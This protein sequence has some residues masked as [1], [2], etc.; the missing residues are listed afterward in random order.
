MWMAKFGSAIVLPE[1]FEAEDEINVVKGI[2]Q[3]REAYNHSP[4]DAEDLIALVG[5]ECGELV[6]HVYDLAESREC[7]LAADEALKFARQQ[8]AKIAILE[9]VDDIQKGDLATPIERMRA[10]LKVG[11]NLL[12]PGI[13]P[14]LDSDKWLF[15]YFEDKVLTGQ[16]HLDV[17]LDGGLGVPELGIILSG[18]NVGKSM[19]LI[20]LG[21]GAASLAG[22]KNVVHFTHEMKPAQV[23]KR[24]AARMLFR[25]PQRDG[26]LLEYQDELLEKAKRMLKG[27]IRIIGGAY[28]MSTAEFETHMDRLIE[29]DF[30][31]GLIIDDYLDLMTPPKHYLERRF[32]LSATYE[33]A[34]SMSEKYQCPFWTATQANRESLSKEII[35]LQAISEDLG[36]AAIADV[37]VALCQT[38]DEGQANQC[39]FFIAKNRDASKMGKSLISAKYYS[40]SQAIITVDFVTRKGEEEIKSDTKE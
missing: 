34:R 27:Q 20:N 25:F 29:E 30:N 35:T 22:G 10:A 21:F 15:D 12:S 8:A 9:G 28:K 23:A 7:E 24:Y 2:L 6:Y 26:N 4:K 19:E 1:Y 37:V 40:S 17:A 39:R 32:E 16:Y 14:I 18:I 5:L 13:N 31:P 3:Y 11:D 38:Y 33:W 36:K